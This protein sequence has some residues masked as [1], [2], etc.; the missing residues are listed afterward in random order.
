MTAPDEPLLEVRGLTK[1]FGGRR[2]FGG[3]SPEVVAVRDASLAIARGDCLG[4]VG[5]SGSGKSTLADCVAGLSVPTRGEV[6]Y[7]GEVVNA[8]GRRPQLPRAHGVTVVFQDPFSSLNPRR[9]VGSVLAEI[10]SVHR[11]RPREAVQGRVEE[12]L[13]RVGLAADVADRRPDR[14]SGGQRQRVAIARALAF[15][16]ALMVADEIVSALDVSVQAQILNLLADLRDELG[17]TVLFITHDLA[18]VRQLCNR[19]AVMN[20]GVIV[21]IDDTESVLAAPSHPYTQELLRAVPRL[22]APSASGSA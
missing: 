8:P 11:L 20:L 15:E 9:T 5:E 13:D 19:V 3:G 2:R 1:V 17:L 12:L 4:L 22:H 21:E 16:P 18:V 10:L 6:R 7:G 14:L